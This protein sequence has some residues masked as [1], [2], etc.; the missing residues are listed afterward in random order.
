MKTFIRLIRRYVLT[1]IAVVLLFLFLGIGMIV[2]ISW[3]E[4]SRL[5]QQEYTASKIADSMAENKNG[6]SFGSAHTPQ[7]WMD[8]YSWAMV[9]DDY[10]YVKWNYLLPDKLNH[11]YTSGDIASFARWYLDD[12][13]VFCWKES[14]GL[15]VI[16]LPKGSLW[17][18]S[19]Y[20]SPEVL[21]DIVH[22][23]PMMFLSLLLLGLIFCL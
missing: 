18:Y 2:W 22:N 15:F 19:L 4:G 3:R 5:P 23:V 11:H 7:E 13:P 10:G 20:N 12:Y 16:G 8:G 14:Y 17:K 6:L 21:R 1:A 9:I